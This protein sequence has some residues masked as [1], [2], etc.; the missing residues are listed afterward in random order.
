[1]SI[2]RQR[3][4]ETDRPGSRGGPTRGGP[5]KKLFTDEMLSE[6]DSITELIY[7]VI[8]VTIWLTRTSQHTTIYSPRFTVH[9]VN[10][11]MM[12]NNFPYSPLVFL[13]LTWQVQD[14]TK[15]YAYQM[16]TLKWDTPHTSCSINLDFRSFQYILTKQGQKS[17][18]DYC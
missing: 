10:H 17:S 8:W 11:S 4:T 6:I 3:N 13:T 7:F 14:I 2:H 12:M 16:P 18:L 1:M 9:S 5:P 15:Y